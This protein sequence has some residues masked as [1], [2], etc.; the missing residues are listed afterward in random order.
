MLWR[1]R[2]WRMRTGE[3]FALGVA[4][5]CPAWLVYWCA[6]VLGSYA[7]TGKYG[8]TV[9]PDLTFMEAL[10]RYGADHGIGPAPSRR[11]RA[12][13]WRWLWSV[14][15]FSWLV[16]IRRFG[17][18]DRRWWVR[19]GR[20]RPDDEGVLVRP[21]RLIV[22][23]GELGRRA[24]CKYQRDEDHTLGIGLGWII[25]VSWGRAGYDWP[26]KEW[27]ISFWDGHLKLAWACDDSEMHYD[28]K[29]GRGRP[30]CGWQWSCF[31]M[32]V[33][34]GRCKYTREETARQTRILTMPEG[35]YQ[36]A[37][38]VTHAT[39][40]RARWPW[41]PLTRTRDRLEAEF[42]PPVGL[43]GKG[44]NSYDCDD[45]A[46]YSVTMPLKHG[47]IQATLNAFAL[48]TLRERQQRGGLTWQP[49]DGWPVAVAGD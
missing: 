40:R 34:F 22:E 47:D 8:A 4:R 33:I 29:G 14:L 6:I 26:G 11:R 46:T 42:D 15:T 37:C 1:L 45:D 27:G 48:D 18:D 23:I 7:T 13:L 3:R 39:W 38:V 20:P 28:G 17:R 19:L 16:S 25:W 31:L 49:Q 43:P 24:M 9:V 44:E 10:E 2:E 30:K 5:H 41:W 32:D 21:L 36:A 35:K 12:R